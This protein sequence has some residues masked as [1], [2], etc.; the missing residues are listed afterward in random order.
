MQL[1]WSIEETARRLLLEST[2]AQENR[3]KYALTTARN[4]AVVERRGHPL[5]STP[6]P[7]KPESFRRAG[8][9]NTR[10]PGTL[11]KRASGQPNAKFYCATSAAMP[12]RCFWGV[13]VV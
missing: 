10:P 4:A 7:R 8:Q 6:H 9:G 3:E 5:K 12:F 1:R 11:T 2:K 13:M